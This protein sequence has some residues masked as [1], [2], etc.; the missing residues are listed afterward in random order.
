MMGAGAGAPPPQVGEAEI[1]YGRIA[2][3]DPVSL[4]GDHQLGPFGLV[5][6]AVGREEDAG[7]VGAHLRGKPQRDL[8]ELAGGLRRAT[9]G[10]DEREE[11][12]GESHPGMVANS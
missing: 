2:Q 7:V 4:D 10:E 8:A 6:G 11:D 3:I 9:S 5:V 12:G 1:R